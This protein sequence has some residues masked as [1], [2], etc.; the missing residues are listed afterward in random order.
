MCPTPH[1]RRPPAPDGSVAALLQHSTGGPRGLVSGVNPM[2]RG[3]RLRTASRRGAGGCR[4]GR[5][6][7]GVSRQAGGL[8]S[9]V[10]SP[11][12]CSLLGPD[13]L[14]REARWPLARARSRPRRRRRPCRSRARSRSMDEIQAVLVRRLVRRPPPVLPVRRQAARRLE[15]PVGQKRSRVPA[16]RRVPDA[17]DRRG[18][19]A[20]RAAGG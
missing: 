8:E 9:A 3:V 15:L 20:D 7:F 16:P 11:P 12:V 2:A 4:C 14:R 5:A 6:R 19:A 18:R 10:G 13:A 17:R 1:S